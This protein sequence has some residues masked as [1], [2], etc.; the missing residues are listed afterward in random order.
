M[1]RDA[2]ALMKVPTAELEREE[3]E[4]FAQAPALSLSKEHALIYRGALALARQSMLPPEGRTR[5]NYYV[6][7]REP[8]WSWGHDGQVFHESLSMLAYVHLDHQVGGRQ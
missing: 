7:S 8:V 5:Y 1:L 2:R 6:F 4:L 3:R